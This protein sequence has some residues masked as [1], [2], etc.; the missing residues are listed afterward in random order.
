M[1]KRSFLPPVKGY[2]NAI[3]RKL[4]LP[5][6]VKVR[7]MS[8]LATSMTARHEAGEPYEAIM[9]DLGAP[10][11]V[12]ARLNEEMAEYAVDRGSPWRWLFLALAAL[13]AVWMVFSLVPILFTLSASASIGVI[14]GADGP[15]AIFLATQPHPTL[16]TFTAGGSA[17]LACLA[18][19]VLLR[20][21]RPVPQRTI[22]TARLLAWAGLCVLLLYPLT[23]AFI[24]AG[25][26]R[27]EPQYMDLMLF[28]RTF[29]VLLLLSLL[30]PGGWGNI[31]ALILIRRRQKEASC[32]E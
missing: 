18:F 5:F 28:P 20:R 9:E 10:A 1:K 3:E 6:Q 29:G 16:F 4:R 7:V 17:L 15:T 27:T 22:R 13:S 12:A 21:G 32:H 24:V 19:Y 30:R 23:G 25:A 14:G 26:V 11:E 2:V 31:A 8:D